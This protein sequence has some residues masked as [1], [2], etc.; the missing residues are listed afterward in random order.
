VLDRAIRCGAYEQC[1]LSRFERRHGNVLHCRLV[2][3]IYHESMV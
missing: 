3:S 1:R 2:G